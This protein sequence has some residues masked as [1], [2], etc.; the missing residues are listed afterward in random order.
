MNS[1]PDQRL[2]ARDRLA[3][4]FEGDGGF[5]VAEAFLWIAAQEFPG[6]D[7]GHHLDRIRIVASEGARRVYNLANPFA[8]I[9][10]LRGYL[11]TELGFRG[12]SDEYNDPRNCYLNE[13]LDRRLG[14]PLTLSLIYMETARAAGFEARGLGLPGHFAV[15]LDRH[16]RSI[17]VDPYHG[18]H[19][20]TEDDCRALVGRTTGR[21]SLFRR[22]LLEG[23]D[24]RAMVA[25]L[26]LNLKHVHV[27]REDYRRALRAVDLL[28]LVS[29]DDPGEIRDRGFLRAHLGEQDAAIE[30]LELY[31]TRSPRAPDADSVR[32]RVSWLRRRQAELG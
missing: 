3:R 18:G 10:G 32:G 21:P 11:F 9:D 12:N 8:R 31:L 19:V 17:L 2:R 23:S 5:D 1:N 16:G 4:L 29:P 28:L 7:V 14:I 20:I 27:E 30:D 26:L 15:R 24:D 22:R 6:L 13:V 25:R